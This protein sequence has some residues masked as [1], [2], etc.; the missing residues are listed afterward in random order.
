M[1]ENELR[2]LRKCAES[3]QKLSQY[4]AFSMDKGSNGLL[5][6]L[7]IDRLDIFGNGNKRRINCNVYSGLSRNCFTKSKT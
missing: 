4:V 2:K 5:V 6:F 7:K 1:Y 3:V